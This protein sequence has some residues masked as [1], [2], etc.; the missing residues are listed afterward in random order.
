M[1]RTVSTL[2][3]LVLLL[4]AA[5]G[6]VTPP[7]NGAPFSTALGTP[8]AQTTPAAPPASSP[9]ATPTLTVAVFP[10][11]LVLVS[12]DACRP[13][14]L[15]LVPTPN[16]DK[17]KGEGVSYTQAWVGQLENNTPP[18][19]ATLSTGAFPKNDGVL[20]F[21]WKD[22][23]NGGV[24][25]PTDWKSVTSGVFTKV[26]A[27]SGATS[28]GTLFKNAHPGAKVA[29]ISSDKFYAAT[30]LGAESADFILFNQARN[31][32][33]IRTGAP[34]DL[35]PAGVAGHLAPAEILND[36]SLRRNKVN[37][38]DGDTWAVDLALKLFE[39]ERPAVLLI[40]LPE[41]DH[42]GHATGGINHPEVMA[43]II[44]NV[45]LQLG[46]LM[47]AY[48]QAGIYERTLWVVTSDH[49]MTPVTM[50][51]SQEALRS[52]VASA[53]TRTGA[54]MSEFYVLNPARAA[55]AA[56]NISAANI[57]GVHGVYYKQRLPDG[58]F[59]YLPSAATARSFPSG[60]DQCFRYLGTTY[61]SARSPEIVLVLAENAHIGNG[62]FQGTHDTV[63]WNDSHIPLV[64]A[65]PG[66]RRGAV[67]ESPARLVDIAP[68]VTAL[69]GVGPKGMDGIILADA[70]GTPPAQSAA[71]QQAANDRFT[72]MVKALQERSRLDLVAL[73]N[74]K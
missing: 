58:S 29:A 9:P 23:A 4:L 38:Y 14:Y 59:S 43:P 42:S 61:A 49:A 47:D 20:G 74:A 35:V 41:T 31:V 65:G 57:P 3:L 45:D 33:D 48:R 60:L 16:L 52:A 32:Q 26:I 8:S 50:K 18:G 46:R 10:D 27:D 66:T 54:A 19:H 70:L 36:P 5:A 63:T 71:A 30:A 22:P 39:K 64:I 72:P 67:S 7:S 53:G 17:L 11:Y 15:S 40:N 28:I 24:V 68:T 44:A 25:N 21:T 37:R 56:D 51:V 69:L 13:D 2:T 73:G 55:Q 12:I 6:C 1:K 34:A 62:K